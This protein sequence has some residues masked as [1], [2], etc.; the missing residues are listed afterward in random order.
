MISHASHS[1]T[2]TPPAANAS[3]SASIDSP[4]RSGLV[5]S[6]SRIEFPHTDPLHDLLR[7]MGITQ[8]GRLTAGAHH[9][10]SASR[11][12]TPRETELDNRNRCR[13]PAGFDSATRS[14]GARGEKDYAHLPANAVSFRRSLT[15][16]GQPGLSYP[17][18]AGSLTDCDDD[19]PRNRAALSFAT[20]VLSLIFLV[21]LILAGIMIKF[22]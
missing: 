14:H 5:H 21:P 11:A 4:T 19:A 1:H 15:G 7:G 20:I 16:R 2:A 18:P 6:S 10:P 13:P 17:M 22:R 9:Q 12:D 3:T 8:D